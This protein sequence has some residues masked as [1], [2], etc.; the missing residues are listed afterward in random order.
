MFKYIN[1]PSTASLLVASLALLPRSTAI[2]CAKGSGFTFNFRGQCDI[3]AFKAAYKEDIY[4]NEARTPGSCTNTLEQEL[5]A[6]FQV[7][8]SALDDAIKEACTAA[9]K[10]KPKM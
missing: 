10:S 7:D 9:Q 8:T 5:A 2:Q 1:R 4:D 3:E 6:Q